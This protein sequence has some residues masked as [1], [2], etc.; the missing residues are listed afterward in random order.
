MVLEPAN[1]LLAAGIVAAMD[2]VIFGVD[3]GIHDHQ[4]IASA[5]PGCIFHHLTHRNIE[6]KG[7]RD[8]TDASNGGIAERTEERIHTGT[9]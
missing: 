7:A 6:N 9:G 4:H 2:G 8:R 5:E 1:H 3:G